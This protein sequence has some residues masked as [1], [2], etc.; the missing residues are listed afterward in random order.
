MQQLS[1]TLDVIGNADRRIAEDERSIIQAIEKRAPGKVDSIVF[2]WRADLSCAITIAS[3]DRHVTLVALRG[4][5]FPDIAAEAL[6][7]LDYPLESDCSYWL[8]SPL[9]D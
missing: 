1:I 2:H 8:R 6:R 9:R 4:Q 5:R 7:I 3:G